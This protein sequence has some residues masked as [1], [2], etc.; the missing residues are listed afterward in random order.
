MKKN[1]QHFTFRGGSWFNTT[2]VGRISFRHYYH[3]D[4]S[5]FSILGFTI[6]KQNSTKT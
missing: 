1:H 3:Y 2:N 5:R 4:Y 6:V